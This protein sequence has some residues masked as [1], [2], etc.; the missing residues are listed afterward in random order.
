M[1]IEKEYK[2]FKDT[3]WALATEAYINID[4]GHDEWAKE[5]LSEIIVYSEN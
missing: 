3:I 4:A 5:R 2:D 1:D